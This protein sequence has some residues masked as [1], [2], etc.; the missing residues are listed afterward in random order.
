MQVQ[1]ILYEEQAVTG[2]TYFQCVLRNIRYIC[3]RCAYSYILFRRLFILY[4]IFI[5]NVYFYKVGGRGECRHV[6]SEAN[7]VIYISKCVMKCL[8]KK[9]HPLDETKVTNSVKFPCKM[10]A[11]NLVECTIREVI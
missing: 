3:N 5:S 2:H 7:E 8:K 6:L 4:I 9:V 1:H 11:Y 10:K